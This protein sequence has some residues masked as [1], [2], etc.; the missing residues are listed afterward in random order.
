MSSYLVDLMIS[1]A[2]TIE[3]VGACVIAKKVT[4]NVMLSDKIL[5]FRL[6][7][8][9]EQ[10]VLF[11]LVSKFGREGIEP[12]NRESRTYEETSVKNGYELFV[13]HC[14]RRIYVNKSS[15]RSTA[16]SHF[17]V[18]P[19]PRSRWTCQRADRRR[20]PIVQMAFVGGHLNTRGELLCA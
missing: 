7:G 19:I 1:R 10:W 4:N 6:L 17:C 3:L 20:Q 2:N 8:G 12:W 14:D 11:N 18:K 5:R 9:L 16:A 15:L 13:S